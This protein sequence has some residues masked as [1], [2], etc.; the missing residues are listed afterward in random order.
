MNGTTLIHL[1][2][3]GL[4]S[5]AFCAAPAQADEVQKTYLGKLESRGQTLE[6]G[7]G[8]VAASPILLQRGTQLVSWAMPMIELLSAVPGLAQQHEGE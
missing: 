6:Q 4:L 7:V 5:V 2:L 3:L 8:R 1:A